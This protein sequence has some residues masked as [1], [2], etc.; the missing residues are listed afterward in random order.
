ME[1]LVK[2]GAN[3]KFWEIPAKT[4]EGGRPTYQLFPISPGDL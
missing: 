3:G 2:N 1:Y 4:L